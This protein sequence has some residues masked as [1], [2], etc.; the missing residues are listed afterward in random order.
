LHICL[1]RILQLFGRNLSI[2]GEFYI[3]SAFPYARDNFRDLERDGRGQSTLNDAHG[4]SES[5][6]GVIDALEQFG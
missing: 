1:E 4:I 3:G 2:V 6:V 5:N